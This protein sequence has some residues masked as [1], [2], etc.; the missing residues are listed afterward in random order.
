MINRYLVI[1]LGALIFVGCKK[2]PDPVLNPTKTVLIL[3]AMDELCTSG[4]V[5]SAAKSTVNFNWNVAQNTD[6]YEISIK[7]LITGQ[8]ITQNTL[9]TSI[10]I[11]LDRNTPYSWTVKSI[12]SSSNITEQSESW[13][14]YN[15]GPGVVFYAPFPAEII[16]P[17]MGQNVS[18]S[19]A[20][21][22]LE[23]KGSDVDQDIKSYDVYFGTSAPVLIKQDVEDSFLGDISI[24]ANTQYYWKIVTKDQKGNTSDSGVYRFKTN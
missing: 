18:I 15:S 20:K 14:F 10:G 21:V 8:V 19:T 13:K 4:T 24:L 6:S 23:W 1:I 16:A 9:K 2:K 3:P 12:S 22:K 7:N 11:E 17:V 5:I